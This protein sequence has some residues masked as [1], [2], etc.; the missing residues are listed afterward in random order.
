[1][2]F[3]WRQAWTSLRGGG[4]RTLLAAI[5]IAFG[6]LSLVALQGIAS[7][8]QS[9]LFV[10]PRMALA[11][12]KIAHRDGALLTADDRN[13][14]DALIENGDLERYLLYAPSRGRMLL[15]ADGDGR[16]SF[17]ARVEGVDVGRFPL[18]GEVV[19][20]DERDLR[21]SL[22]LGHAL[23]SRDLADKRSLT[24]GETFTLAGPGQTPSR[25]TVGGIVISTPDH[26]G[27][28][29]LYSLETA[30][31]LA[32]RDEVATHAVLLAPSEAAITRLDATGWSLRGPPH[33]DP[34]SAAFLRY[35]FVGA[36]LLGL[37]IG[38]LGL[39]NTLQFIFTSR[40]RELAT[41]RALG[42]ARR[43]LVRLF[44]IELLL[45]GTAGSLVGVA[46]GYAVAARLIAVLRP[47]VNL[48]LELRFDLGMSVF[49]VLAGIATTLIFGLLAAG[50]ALEVEPSSLLRELRE[51]TSRVA[52]RRRGAV[53]TLA[54]LLFAVLAS[55]IIGSA[56]VGFGVVLGGLMALGLA[57][58]AFRGAL[59]AVVRVPISAWP[60]LGLARRNLG[61]RP[62]RAAMCM[63]ALAA[64]T[65]AIG[66]AA[67]AFDNARMRVDAR[68][69][70]LEHDNI[71]VFSVPADVARVRDTSDAAGWPSVARW[72]HPSTVTRAD[73]D[74]TRLAFVSG[75]EGRDPRD[76]GMGIEQTAGQPWQAQPGTAL[77][78]E[79]SGD[80]EDSP[81]L[82]DRLV[83]HGPE[84]TIE[85]EVA[86]RYRTTAVSLLPQRV[87]L[88]ISRADAEA[89]VADD[90][91]V[92]MYLT[93]PRASIDEA[94]SRLG[95]AV[96]EAMV[97]SRADLQ[98]FI[99][100]TLM[101]V[102]YF[103][104]GLAALA[105]VAGAVLVANAVGLALIERRR[106]IGMLKAV[107][108]AR[109]HLMLTLLV[110]YGLLGLLGA[111]AGLA[112]TQA[113]ILVTRYRFPNEALYL[114]ASDA[115]ALLL[116]S[117]VLTTTIAALLSWR[118]I[119]SSPMAILRSP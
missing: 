75:I 72:T 7:T 49:A 46:A 47:S 48:L 31:Q 105:L 37:L 82:G 107:G 9:A 28:L 16:V 114:G 42:F 2:S 111:A 51:P 58:L 112:G 83:V 39:A 1:M 13:L 25:F 15:R 89:L 33:L 65:F 8:F 61:H 36:G 101:S 32:G 30:R 60:L 115:A 81:A 91:A 95:H 119:R 43:D 17:A 45:L 38:A 18:V 23:I 110:E 76:A 10:E 117:I 74:A 71:M 113:A 90:L 118:P 24:V 67:T 86:G 97:V 44:T 69:G 77:V 92:T 62:A 21:S 27:G 94:A 93:A 88:L 85:V 79:R 102:F 116:A 14:L 11:G 98:D 22:P 3:A 56:R 52:R 55:G 34:E 70:D 99:N 12:D 63:V 73:G 26:R 103:V 84:G 108:Y 100:G 20:A 5:C 59:A 40:Q 50:R 96:P 78:P 57:V 54:V 29:V 4:Q 87:S 6:V 35:L 80:G 53:T 19:L 41:L 104:A 64:G 106:E 109:R 66:F 68:Q